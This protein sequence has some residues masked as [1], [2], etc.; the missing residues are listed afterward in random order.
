MSPDLKKATWLIR[1]FLASVPDPTLRMG[2]TIVLD[3]LEAGAESLADANL[4]EEE[5]RKRMS[6]RMDQHWNEALAAKFGPKV[7]VPGT[8][9]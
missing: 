9:E 7:P 3:M 1:S 2:T 5:F 8:G 6:D 4:P